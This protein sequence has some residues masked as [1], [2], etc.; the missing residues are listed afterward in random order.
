MCLVS[1]FSIVVNSFFSV[2]IINL[3]RS[4]RW[5]KLPNSPIPITTRAKLQFQD[6][7]KTERL[8]TDRLKTERLKT[9]R[10][11]KPGQKKIL[12]WRISHLHISIA[13]WHHRWDHLMCKINIVHW[14]FAENIKEN[15]RFNDR[16]NMS[17]MWNSS[18]ISE[19]HWIMCYQRLM[20]AW[21]CKRLLRSGY[22]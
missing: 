10:V 4:S 21:T 15:W 2:H 8:K 7:K 1:F 6:E 3:Y 11:K 9:K 20:S 19:S 5:N 14:S 22:W 17:L 18:N 16:K 13:N 12:H